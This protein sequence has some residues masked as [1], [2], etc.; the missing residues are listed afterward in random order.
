MSAREIEI[1]RAVERIRRIVEDVRIDAEDRKD[2]AG[3][4]FEKIL[5]V[6]AIDDWVSQELFQ[7][8]VESLSPRKKSFKEIRINAK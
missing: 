6:R 5:E 8:R 7:F 3:Y 2:L 4:A 1:E